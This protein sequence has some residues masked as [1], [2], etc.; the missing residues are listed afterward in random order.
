MR[1]S[2]DLRVSFCRRGTRSAGRTRRRA[3]EVEELGGGG[4]G[5]FLVVVWRSMVE[6]EVGVG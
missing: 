1:S 3:D 6:D 5:G 2:D 4:G